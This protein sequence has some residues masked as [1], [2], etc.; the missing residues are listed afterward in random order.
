MALFLTAAASRKL[1]YRPSYLAINIF[2]IS[3]KGYRGN[4]RKYTHG[5]VDRLEAPYDVTSL[6]HLPKNSWSTNG[7]NTIQ[8]RAGPHVTL[9]QRKGLSVVDQQQL[10][11]LYKC[12]NN[13]GKEKIVIYHGE[14]R[15]AIVVLLRFLVFSEKEKCT[16]AVL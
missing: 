2:F 9:G 5:E 14:E 11:Q 12:K 16:N 10:N 6:M 7:R 13:R 15:V 8:S 3:L 1:Y 4:F